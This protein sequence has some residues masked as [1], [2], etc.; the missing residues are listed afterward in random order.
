MLKGILFFGGQS[1]LADFGLWDIISDNLFYSLDQD[2]NN[3]P[4]MVISRPRLRRFNFGLGHVPAL[5]KYYK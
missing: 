4:I 2:G 5:G 3:P 1:T